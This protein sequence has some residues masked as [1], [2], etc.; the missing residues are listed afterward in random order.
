[1]KLTLILSAALALSLGQLCNAQTTRTD[2]FGDYEE[3]TDTK[4]HDGPEV[5]DKIVASPQLSWGSTDVRYSKRSIPSL[6]NK[7]HWQTKAW[8]GERVNAQAV[9]WTKTDLSGAEITVSDLRNGSSIIPAS[10]IETSF[11]R[12]VMTDELSKDGTTGCGERYNKADWDSS[13]VAD[14]LDIINVRDIVARTTQPVWMNAW[15]PSDAKTGKYK[16]TLTVTGSNFSPLSLQIEIDVLNHTLPDPK[17]WQIHM[18]LW[19]NP[20]AVA[21]YYDVPLW[22]KEHFDAMRPIMK[23]IA[24][25]GQKAVTA[26]I[27]HKP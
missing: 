18:D 17:D 9:L 7:K 6:Q 23:R 14:A 12:Y 15:V 24:Q 21:R 27:M 22:S 10:A 26:S 16:G 8:K 13:M 5:W 1:M 20:Y 4:P 19:Q 2:P 11:V 3:L 25:T